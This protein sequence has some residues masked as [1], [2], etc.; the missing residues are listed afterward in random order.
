MLF[1]NTW[2]AL[3][4]LTTS[5]NRMAVQTTIRIGRALQ[6]PF[7]ISMNT[8]GIEALYTIRALTADTHKPMGAAFTAPIC[9][10]TIST[11]RTRIGRTAMIQ[12]NI[13]TGNVIMNKS[14]LLP[15]AVN[16]MR[17]PQADLRHICNDQ[18][19][20]QGHKDKWHCSLGNL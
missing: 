8:W 16:H 2:N 20:D 1:R 4:S 10:F 9:N 17:Q 11:S 19:S 15:L 6:T 13:V 3:A 12:V 5:Y 14:F 7:S 18:Q